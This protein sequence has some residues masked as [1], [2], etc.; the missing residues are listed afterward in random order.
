VKKFGLA[1]HAVVVLVQVQV[2]AW[3]YGTTREVLIYD[4]HIFDNV[5]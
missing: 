3:N 5:I 4:V 2:L 1:Q